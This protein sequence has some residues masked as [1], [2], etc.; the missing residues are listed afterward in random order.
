MSA[1]KE[2]GDFQTPLPLAKEIIGLV[3]SLVGK[4]ARVV[5]PTAGLG[6]FLEAAEEKWGSDPAYKGYEL[7]T[8]YAREANSRL[9]ARGIAIEQQDFFETDWRSIL[10]SADSEKV[11]V[12]GNPPWVTNAELGSLGSR[13]L[14]KKTN[15]QGLRGF[16]AKTGKANFDIAE[17]MLIRLIEAL[18]SSGAMAMLCKTMTARKVLRYFWKIDG[19][20]EQASLFLIDAK[21][22]FDV[23]VDACLFFLRG[24]CCN[25]RTATVYATLDAHKKLSEFG[26][27]DG[28]L[29]SDISN[30]KALRDLDGGSPYTWRSGL[31]HDAADIMELTV[32]HGHY[33]NGLDQTV[34]IESNYVFPLLKS[35]DIGNGRTIPRKFVLVTQRSTGE[36]T[37]VIRDV[38][39]KTW[40]YLEAHADKLDARRSSI[41]QNRPRFSIFG[42]GAYSFAPWK[43]AI[44]G[45]YNTFRFVVVSPE[46]ERPVMLDDTCY[47]IPCG[48]KKEAYLIADLLNSDTSQ[49]FLRSLV[50]PDSK[51]PITTDVLRRLSLVALACHLGRLEELTPYVKQSTA[52]RDAGEIQLQLVMEQG[53]EYRTCPPDSHRAQ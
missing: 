38:A 8:T 36:D 23:S 27:V 33:V 45:L 25:E 29:V 24:R 11:L 37:S 49:R 13:N 9:S 39:P 16:E 4:P 7:N 52:Y 3:D 28:N 19:G 26:F 20:R 21:K 14:P 48:S 10:S 6:V 12:V 53:K 50:F 34:D 5:E 46:A 44:S 51:R 42:I 22:Q 32:E 17:W 31:K 35:S 1:K 41:Y 43:V 30:Y 40:A 47:F 18:P 15:F 2:F